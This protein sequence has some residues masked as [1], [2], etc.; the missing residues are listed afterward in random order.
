MLNTQKLI[1]LLPDVTYI[2]ELLPTKKEHTFAIQSFRQIN[3]EFMT[4]DDELIPANCTKLLGKIDPEEYLLVLPDHLFTNTIVSI[5]ET[6]ESKVKEEIKEKLLPSLDLD[7]D[8]HDVK[9]FIVTQHGGKSKVQISALEKSVLEAFRVP[10]EKQGVKIKGVYPLSW[11]IKSVISL[12]PSISVI[13]IGTRLYSALHY[14]G[15]DQTTS[16]TTA[17]V[18]S[19]AETIK[20]LK[21]AEP[22]IQTV[23]LLTNELV[24]QELKKELSDTLPLQ[25]L[26]NYVENQTDLP[27]FVKHIIE[28][29]LRTLSIPDF[30]VPE[31]PLGKILGT[32]TEKDDDDTTDPDEAEDTDTDKEVAMSTPAVLPATPPAAASLKA[33]DVFADDTEDEDEPEEDKSDEAEPEEADDTSDDSEADDSPEL[34]TPTPPAI[35]SAVQDEEVRITEVVENVVSVNPAVAS[36]S[37]PQVEEPP[38]PEPKAKDPLI[39]D[40]F[41]D[42]EEKEALARDTDEDT[43]DDTEELSSGSAEPDISK[44]APGAALAAERSSSSPARVSPINKQKIKNRGQNQSL[45][46]MI[47]VTVIVFLVTVGVGVGVGLGL[48]SLT[49]RDTQVT[50]SPQV[51]VTPE[52]TP[53]A[54]TTTP[55]PSPSPTPVEIDRSEYS[56]LVVNATTVSGFAGRYQ[57]MLQ[58]EGYDSVAAGNARGEYTAGK[59]YVLLG[60]NAAQLQD[61]LEEDTGLTLAQDEELEKS[62]EDPRNQYDAVIVLA[63]E[64]AE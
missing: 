21:G 46:R 9:T 25:Q 62:T 24:E 48:L 43:T 60:E 10:A 32:L 35:T 52:P 30:P 12:E 23:Y 51:S 61:V 6:S 57:R 17:E 4:E 34:P 56:V 28:S 58:E 44:F 53:I 55:S 38:A 1:Y 29:G 18:T 37:I 63:D 13:Q 59:N 16:Q 64:E 31:F 54:E 39:K 27:A 45:V 2:A 50:S 5:N 26:T 33:I 15:V 14:I 8:T 20:T 19:I 41:A 7:K 47:A 40:P 42:A 3:G 11:T 36:M 22:S 49:S